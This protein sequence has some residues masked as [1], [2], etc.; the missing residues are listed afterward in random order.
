MLHD[1]RNT[2]NSQNIRANPSGSQNIAKERNSH[3]TKK[4]P[5]QCNKDPQFK[6]ATKNAGV[7]FQIGSESCFFCVP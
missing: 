7:L 2:K 4:N 3:I 6:S 5:E 1:I